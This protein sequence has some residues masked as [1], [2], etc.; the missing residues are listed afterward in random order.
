MDPI[1]LSYDN[2]A[3]VPEAFRSLFEERDGKAILTGVNGMKTQADVDTVKEALRKERENHSATQNLLKPWQA[4]KFDEVTSK[5]SRFD[6][7]EAASKGKIDETK[8]EEIVNGRLKQKTGPLEVALAE[9]DT[10]IK[11]VTEEN[12]LLKS[13]ISDRDRNDIVRAA[14]AQTKVHGTAVADVEMAAKMMME[15]D[16]NGKLVTKDGLN[17]VPAGLDIN[18]FMK[19]MMKTRPHWWPESEGGGSRGGSG[20]GIGGKNPWSKDSWNMTEQGR[21][22]REEGMEVATRL[23]KAAGSSIG[24]TGPKV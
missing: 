15:F 4:L 6:E 13:N 18:G 23:A 14:A 5:L 9:R 20:G 8:I 12:A 11:T 3:A 10:T 1:E 16:E 7:L 21:I 2:L 19:A 22:A 24:A 17:G